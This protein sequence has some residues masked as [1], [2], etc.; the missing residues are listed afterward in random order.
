MHW[1]ISSRRVL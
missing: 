1:S